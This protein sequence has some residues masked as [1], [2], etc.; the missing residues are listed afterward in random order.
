MK[1]LKDFGTIL[2]SLNLR[3]QYIRTDNINKLKDASLCYCSMGKKKKKSIEVV[4]STEDL[5]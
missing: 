1:L 3:K 5:T 4:L 2:S